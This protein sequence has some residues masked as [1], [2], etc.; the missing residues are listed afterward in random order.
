M[1]RGCYCVGIRLSPPAPAPPR[2]GF[3][4]VAVTREPPRTCDTTPCPQRNRRN[5]SILPVAGTTQQLSM[6]CPGTTVFS[7]TGNALNAL[8]LALP[9]QLT[10]RFSPCAISD[11]CF[12]DGIHLFLYPEEPTNT[13]MCANALQ[14]APMEFAF[15]ADDSRIFPYIAALAFGKLRSCW[16]HQCH[17]QHS[18]GAPTSVCQSHPRVALLLLD[19]RH[20]AGKPV[21]A[22]SRLPR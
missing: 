4:H 21:H 11:P 22:S 10:A 9:A 18:A 16:H 14:A 20:T 8:F 12:R 15:R 2:G 1:H 13:S 5:R 19:H 6:Q 7:P 3:M 17:R